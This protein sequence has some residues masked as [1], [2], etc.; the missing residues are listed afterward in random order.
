MET[1]IKALGEDHES[2]IIAKIESD[3]IDWSSRRW[4]WGYFGPRRLFDLN[5]DLI[6]DSQRVLGNEYP[7]TLQFMSHT[8]KHLLLKIHFPKAIA[9]GK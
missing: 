3:E 8:A 6:K 5:L 7:A 9:L 2:T 4:L 1:T